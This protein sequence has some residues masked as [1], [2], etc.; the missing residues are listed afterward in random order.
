MTYQEKIDKIDKVIAND[1]FPTVKKTIW[2]LKQQGVKLN[3]KQLDYLDAV[4]LWALQDILATT[5]N[6]AFAAIVSKYL[7]KH[8][9]DEWNDEDVAADVDSFKLNISFEND[10]ENQI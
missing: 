7:K 4:V 1:H 10:S 5:K 2:L 6:S 3:A 9:P 8:F